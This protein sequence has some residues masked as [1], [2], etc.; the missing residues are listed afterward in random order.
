LTHHRLIHQTPT[1]WSL[2]V[3]ASSLFS[4]TDLPVVLAPRQE[5]A[6]AAPEQRGAIGQLATLY[7]VGTKADKTEENGAMARDYATRYP[8]DRLLPM[9]EMVLIHPEWT[10]DE[11]EDIRVNS[12][13][14]A[15]A[16]GDATRA[17]LWRANLRK[18]PNS[19]FTTMARGRMLR[20]A[21]R[22]AAI[23]AGMPVDSGLTFRDVAVVI[24]PL[25]VPA[26]THPAKGK[27]R[28]RS[29]TTPPSLSSRL[30]TSRTTVSVSWGNPYTSPPGD[31]PRQAWGFCYP[32][33]DWNGRAF[34]EAHGP[35]VEPGLGWSWSISIETPPHTKWS[36]EAKGRVR[37][38]NLRKRL[39][40][41]VPL[42]ADLLFKEQL[43]A[44]PDYFAGKPYGQVSA[45]TVEAAQV[46]P[47]DASLIG[48]NGGPPLD[49]TT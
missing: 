34:A 19:F 11:I 32:S 2:T 47:D 40:A 16:E 35:D 7:G 48:H 25:A 49:P 21:Q 27:G 45:V 10:A 31:L 44:R 3:S 42:F 17:N 14:L 22:E 20:H 6:G 37:R 39:E 41:K 18:P 29:P 8:A 33:D 46:N 12:E 38:R 5:R 4:P 36:E 1:T 23:R 28:A 13:L 24:V 30:Q 9:P 26:V 43:E 15:Q